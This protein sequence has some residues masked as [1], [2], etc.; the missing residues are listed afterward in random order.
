ML[1]LGL[2]LARLCLV[3]VDS[4]WFATAELVAGTYGKPYVF[5]QLAPLAVRTVMAL[6]GLA[7]QPAA[8]WVLRVACVGWLAALWYL[9]RAVVGERAAIAALLV[10]PALIAPFVVGMYVYDVP[11]LALFTLGLAW[12][13]RGRWLPYLALFP[14]AILCQEVAAFLVPVFVLQAKA[15]LARR[16]FYGALAWQ[17]GTLALIKVSLALRYAANEGT[18]AESHLAAHY[19]YLVQFPEPHVGVLLVLAALVGLVLVLLRWRAVPAAFVP[20]LLLIPIF[21]FAYIGLG[22]P[23]EVRAIIGVYPVLVVLLVHIAADFGSRLVAAL[24]RW[25]GLGSWAPL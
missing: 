16:P 15:H 6:T 8:G 24:A 12:L 7:V 2:A 22:Y 19:H 17:L 13:V 18:A 14:V 9:A 25:R 21:F 1:A 23:G 11:S 3:N 20:A 5:R 4:R 10:A